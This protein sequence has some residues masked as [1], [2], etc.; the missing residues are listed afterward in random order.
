[1]LSPLLS[2]VVAAV[3]ILLCSGVGSARKF[4]A[5][6][7]I[8]V[9][10]KSASGDDDNTGPR[11]KK[12][13]AIQWS[14]VNGDD[15]RCESST[16]SRRICFSA[17][18]QQRAQRIDG[19][20]GSFLR[21]GAIV[22]NLLSP[23]V[24]ERLLRDYFAVGDE[25][26][27]SAGF[28]V[29]KVESTGNDFA[30]I[31]YE[32]NHIYFTYWDE[33]PLD[34]GR[35][36]F[37]MSI[38]LTRNG[39]VPFIQR[40]QSVRGSNI[41]LQSDSDYMPAWMQNASSAVPVH[42][43]QESTSVN[44]SLY[45]YQ[46][47]YWLE[48]VR[49]MRSHNISIYAIMHANEPAHLPDLLAYNETLQRM[50]VQGSYQFASVDQLRDFVSNYLIPLFRSQS[51][52][53]DVKITYGAQFGRRETFGWFPDPRLPAGNHFYA[54]S[55]NYTRLALDIGDIDILATHAYDCGDTS[56]TGYVCSRGA[57]DSNA[58]S[59]SK[60]GHN[61]TCVNLTG[62]MS[63]FKQ[64]ID[65]TCRDPVTGNYTKPAWVTEACLAIEFGDYQ[66]KLCPTI[67]YADFEL[68][69]TFA[70]AHFGDIW[71]G[72]S[73]SI[74]WNM[75]LDTRGGPYAVSRS[76]NNPD[77][78]RQQPMTIVDWEKNTY[79]HTGV[80]YAYAAFSRA[81]HG[82]KYRLLHERSSDLVVNADVFNYGVNLYQMVF[83]NDTHVSV[84]IMNDALT[85][86]KGFTVVIDEFRSTP[87]DVPAASLV[88][89]DI[90]LAD[91]SPVAV[92]PSSAGVV[93]GI[94]FS[95]LA[96]VTIVAVIVYYRN[97]MMA[98]ESGSS[99]D[100]YFQVQGRETSPTGNTREMHQ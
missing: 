46:A 30:P 92:A 68:A 14:R 2:L 42:P 40:A 51:D 52:V 9:T 5:V 73:A 67:P 54:S 86:Y 72:S 98:Q 48:F 45:H 33:S 63:V 3:V 99:G 93:A 56:P 58:S 75:L 23:D 62:A 89:L 60:I 97:N 17:A 84:I 81:T 66:E 55:Q 44:R 61:L 35:G 11:F 59:S 78:N 100:G 88:T 4:P 37:N 70:R 87:I 74:H 10:A 85:E 65:A 16:S 43:A 96:A 39:T 6:G 79:Y 21:S 47:Q 50:N 64:A 83:A 7:K 24:Q 36:V 15:D 80:F 27:E 38:E 76:H 91:V 34:G 41:L 69:L 25:D 8:I 71:A 20:G 49:A 12:S 19:F 53:R 90:P 94:V 22:L 13:G 77:K 1:M 82:G 57:D 32:K 18:S 28:A 29:G 31:S 26:S 95:F